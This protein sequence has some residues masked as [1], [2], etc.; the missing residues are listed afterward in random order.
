[1]RLLPLHTIHRAVKAHPA[2]SDSNFNLRI[3]KAWAEIAG[4]GWLRKK[5]SRHVERV[6]GFTDLSIAIDFSA[7]FEVSEITT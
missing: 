3:Q 5:K 1:M 2:C 7:F 4:K 6:F